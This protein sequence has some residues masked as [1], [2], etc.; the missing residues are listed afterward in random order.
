MDEGYVTSW[1][2]IGDVGQGHWRKWIGA[3]CKGM[4]LEYVV[5]SHIG[6]IFTIWC[7]IVDI[8]GGCWAVIELILGDCWIENVECKIAGVTHEKILIFRWYFILVVG[9]EKLYALNIVDG[10]I[11]DN[12]VKSIVTIVARVGDNFRAIVGH[13]MKAD[14]A[15]DVIAG[16]F[17][18]INDLVLSFGLLV[19]IDGIINDGRAVLH[20]AG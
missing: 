12:C 20:I 13:E 6:Y 17:E 7:E 4:Q 1:A 10:W 16:R 8:G 14:C 9:V 18:V 5:A 11:V 15:E 3:I 19:E 2:W